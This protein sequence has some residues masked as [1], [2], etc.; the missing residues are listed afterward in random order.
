VKPTWIIWIAT[1]AVSAACTSPGHTADERSVASVATATPELTDL[2][3]SIEAGGIVRSRV[4]A[5]IASRVMAPIVDVRVRAGDRV[6]R[7]DVLVT[8]D[9]RDLRAN[10]ARAQATTLSAVESVRAAEADVRAAESAAHLARLT[11]DRV[12]TLQA[13]RS[14]TTDELDQAAAAL[15]TAEAQHGAAQARLAAATAGREAAK[16]AADAAAV[17][18]TYATLTA[19]FAGIV[20]ERS[21]EP[22]SMAAPGSS[23]LTLEDPATYRL[24]VRLDDTRAAQIAPGGNAAVQL[25]DR[26]PS[27]SGQIAEIARIDPAS[28]T[29]LVKLDLPAGLAVRSGQFGRATFAGPSR[30][31]LTIPASALI[32]RGQLTFVFLLGSDQ[33]THLQ[34]VSIGTVAGDRVEVLAGVRQ[35]DRVVT[36]PQASLA[37]GAAVAGK[38]S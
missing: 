38:Q 6:R 1:A 17:T 25:D 31:A 35:T 15:A 12:A 37:D 9:A 18:T 28:H 7:G 32:R 21:A 36:S 29:F 11:H 13:K 23:L 8:L 20:T 26:D 10:D 27:M 3:S 33:R 30:R 34:P 5:I 22:G 16:A 24:E 4:T 14:A 2:A 19:P